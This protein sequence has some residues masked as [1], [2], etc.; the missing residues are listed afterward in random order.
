MVSKPVKLPVPVPLLVK[1]LAVVDVELV[2]QQTPRAVTV[3]P[4]SAVMFPPLV[5]VDVVIKVAAVV[6]MVAITAVAAIVIWSP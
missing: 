5:A 1:L 6:V 4:P 2:D 3:A